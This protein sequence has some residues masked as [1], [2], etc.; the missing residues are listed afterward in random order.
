MRCFGLVFDRI[1]LYSVSNL[2]S[3]ASIR[4]HLP[5]FDLLEVIFDESHFRSYSEATLPLEI[6]HPCVLA[7][8]V[9]ANHHADALLRFNVGGGF[10][11]GWTVDGDVG[12][13]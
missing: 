11:E 9:V 2:A 12:H 10:V 1:R 7:K 13:V 8:L 4:L 3:L 5:C 6:L